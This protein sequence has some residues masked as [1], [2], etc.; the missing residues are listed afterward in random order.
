MRKKKRDI[1]EGNILHQTRELLEQIRL[2]RL[3]FDQALEPELIEAYVFELNALQAKYNYF[4]RLA[5]E[6][7]LEQS[8]AEFTQPLEAIKK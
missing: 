8:Y 2:T 1:E 6:M 5:R 3:Q 4:L 7:E